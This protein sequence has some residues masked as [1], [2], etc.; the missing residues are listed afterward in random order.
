MPSIQPNPSKRFPDAHK[1]R[2]RFPEGRAGATTF[3]T[4]D[5]A[6]RFSRMVDDYGL[7]KA[8]EMI[9]QPVEPKRLDT[10]LTVRQC[11]E[12]YI[13]QRS[14]SNTRDAYGDRARR[15]IYPQL[16]DMRINRLTV[17]QVQ[18]WLNAQ[19][20]AKGTG[21]QHRHALLFSALS[22]AVANGEIRVNPARKASPSNRSGV[23]I[24][25]TPRAKDPI[26]LTRDEFD[27]IHKSMSFQYKV[28]VEFLVE[29]GCR[30]G[31]AAA[32][33]PGDVDFETGKVH[34]HK[35]YSKNGKGVYTIGMTK[36]VESERTIRVP[37]RVI[38]HLDRSGEFLFST[39]YGERVKGN[40]FHQKHWVKALKAS[41]LPK[42]RFARIHDLRHTHAS[43]LI[44]AG[45]SLPAIQK[46]L[47]HTDV[48]TTLRIY[49]HPATDSED[50]ILAALER[51]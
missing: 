21:L 31:E 13:E 17:E 28:L 20:E 35:T 46:R 24:P 33:T 38:E 18:L 27:L 36:S 15:H 34:I 48:M 23:R 37:M 39:T 2:Y 6:A 25:R 50:K 41:G 42:H 26:F 10:G 1:V 49:G 40:S 8:L 19:T 22:A 4:L 14:N 32:L 12:R 7:V 44:D 45:V 47:G 30:F 43:W 3:D 16:G 11:V 5:K 29:S 9:D 51:F